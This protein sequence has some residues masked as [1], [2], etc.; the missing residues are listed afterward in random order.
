[1]ICPWCE[2]DDEPRALHAHLVDA[3]L[4]RVEVIERRGRPHYSIACPVCDSTYDK[5]IKPRYRDPGFVEEFRREIALVGFDMLINH[6]MAEH[7]MA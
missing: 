2:F 5:E 7:E 6:L 3:H 1:V 4:E